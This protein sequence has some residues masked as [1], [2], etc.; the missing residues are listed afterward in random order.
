[1]V[2]AGFF[3]IVCRA[4]FGLFHSKTTACEVAR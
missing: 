4:S 1:M 3:V 2:I